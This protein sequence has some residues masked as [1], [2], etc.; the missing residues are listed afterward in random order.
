M[1]GLTDHLNRIVESTI[2]DSQTKLAEIQSWIDKLKQAGIPVIDLET[3]YLKAQD[4]VQRLQA[5]L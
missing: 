3:Q 4:T 5:L 1:N 2:Q